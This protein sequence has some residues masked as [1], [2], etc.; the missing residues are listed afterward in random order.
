ML[1]VCIA[2][3]LVTQLWQIGTFF[4]CSLA[5]LSTGLWL[6]RWRLVAAAIVSLS[7]FLMIY[8][9]CWVQIGCVPKMQRLMF[10]REQALLFQVGGELAKYER[11]NREYPDFL[12]ELTELDERTIRRD[13]AGDIL[14]SWGHA[15]HYQNHGDYYELASLGRDGTLGGLGL[16]GDVYFR[17]DW[18]RDDLG[19][20]LAQFLFEMPGSQGVFVI[21]MIASFAAAGICFGTPARYMLPTQ[22]QIIGIVVTA[23]CATIV[24]VIVATFFIVA[25]QAG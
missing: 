18:N 5:V 12:W 19:L 11:K 6:R 24:A 16:D 1:A 13:T 10:A 25:L 22:W 7:V 17:R 8:L 14:D 9:A 2:L 15:L 21:A 23:I 4:C 20:P 3:A